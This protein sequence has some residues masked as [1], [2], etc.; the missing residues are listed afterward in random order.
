MHALRSTV[1]STNGKDD[2]HRLKRGCGGFE[3]EKGTAFREKKSV[4]TM[5]NFCDLIRNI[6]PV[7]F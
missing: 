4:G 5:E 6:Q 3:S 2:E 1:D 7:C